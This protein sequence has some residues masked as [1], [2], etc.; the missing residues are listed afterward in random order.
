MTLRTTA[1]AGLLFVALIVLLLVQFLPLASRVGPGF[2]QPVLALAF[3]TSRVPGFLQ[4]LLPLGNKDRQRLAELEAEVAELRLQQDRMKTAA[5]QNRELRA[6]L[7]LPPPSAWT[8]IAAPIIARDPVSWDRRFRI[9]KGE[10]QGV[11]LGAAVMA[12]GAVIGRITEL[13]ANS[14]TVL[15]VVDPRCR[16]SVRVERTAALGIMAGRLRQGFT[17]EPECLLDYLPRDVNYA[18]GARV[19]TSGLSETVPGGILV[20]YLRSWDEKRRVNVV[21]SSYAQA[22]VAPAASFDDT[23]FVFVLVMNPQP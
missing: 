11:R 9:G 15:T 8:R 2:Y 10:R 6:M 1:R 14:A 13:S 17:E 16:L 19:E 23:R 4:K 12:G 5:E 22:L 3:S 18:D 20:G 21:N 7:D